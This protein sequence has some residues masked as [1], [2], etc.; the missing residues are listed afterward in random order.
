MRFVRTDGGRFAAGFSGGNAQDCVARA[1]AN[2]TQRPYAEIY[3]GL[4]EVNAAT[5]KTDKRVSSAGKHTASRGIYTKTPMFKRYMASLGL[6]W[7]PTMAIG[8][9]CTVHLRA[10]ELPPGRLVVAVSKHYTAVLDGVLHDTHDCSRG[11]S[12]CVYGYWR[13]T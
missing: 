5:R 11:G 4:V 10:A 8:S 2:V 3:A 12:R 7:T 13:L 1:I 6:V 9:G